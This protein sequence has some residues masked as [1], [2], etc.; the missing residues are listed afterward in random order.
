[1]TRSVLFLCTGNSARSQMAEALLRRRWGPDV[2]VVSAG[3]RPTAVNPH[4]VRVLAEVGID[5]SAARSKPLTAFV[6]RSFD[7]VVT[8]CDAAREACPVF[9]GA[10]RQLHWSFEDP[11]AAVGSEAERLAVFRRIRDEIDAAVEALVKEE[12]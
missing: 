9:P 10:R 4:T 5:W 8:V 6:G 7:L 11:A 3:T 12:G 2:E 1:M